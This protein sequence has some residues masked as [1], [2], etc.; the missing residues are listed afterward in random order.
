M[1]LLRR[2]A[3]RIM[4]WELGVGCKFLIAHQTI[5]SS[6]PFQLTTISQVRRRPPRQP[7]TLHRLPPLHHLLRNPPTA[8]SQ[9]PADPRLFRLQQDAERTHDGLQAFQG[10]I[11]GSGSRDGR[12]VDRGERGADEGCLIDE[13]CLSGGW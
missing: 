4:L 5:T 10:G 3:R 7:R 6:E 12:S 13:Y 9:R 11:E 8:K 1:M 2:G